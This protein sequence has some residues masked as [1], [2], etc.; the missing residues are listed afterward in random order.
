MKNNRENKL[1]NKKIS[2]MKLQ[3]YHHRN[4]D[5]ASKL[6]SISNQDCV[7]EDLSYLKLILNNINVIHLN[8]S[9]VNCSTS[10]N[11]ISIIDENI[12]YEESNTKQV[13]LYKPL[14]SMFSETGSEISLIHNNTSHDYHENYSSSFACKE[15]DSNLDQS[16]LIRKF[17]KN[18][19]VIQKYT[20]HIAKRHKTRHLTIFSESS[21]RNDFNRTL[22]R[23]NNNNNSTNYTDVKRTNC[24]LVLNNN[25]NS[26][27]YS[28]EQITDL[29]EYHKNLEEQIFELSSKN[30][31]C[32][33]LA[34]ELNHLKVI[35]G[36][37]LIGN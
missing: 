9:A 6:A 21:F 33:E 2:K 37:F 34:T 12:I 25:Q 7:V 23:I 22:Y 1:N 14:N 8:E 13:V 16:S 30:K 36:C 15:I 32:E 18:H 28:S 24:D 27:I 10:S 11:K 29:Q 20:K 31:N 35:F 17:K 4:Y 5:A 3:P 19:N 26:T